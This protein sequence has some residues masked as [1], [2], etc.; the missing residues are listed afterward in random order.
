MYYEIKFEFLILKFVNILWLFF[1]LE[2]IDLIDIV[3]IEELEF[4][5]EI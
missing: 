2:L 1:F 5:I 4:E 3:I